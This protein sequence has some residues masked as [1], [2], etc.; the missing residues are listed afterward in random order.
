MFNHPML[1]LVRRYPTVS[2]GLRAGFCLLLLWVFLLTQSLALAAPPGGSWAGGNTAYTSSGKTLTISDL[3]RM[4][5]GAR[6]QQVQP[7]ELNMLLENQG[8]AKNAA[9]PRSFQPALQMFAATHGDQWQ[10]EKTE[11]E[12]KE[13][14]N[15]SGASAGANLH[16]PSGG[17]GN[18]TAV[19]LFVLIA[20]VV[21]G[22]VVLAGGKIVYDMLMNDENT[23]AFF[24]AEMNTSSF[25][26]EDQST[27]PPQVV[28][29]GRLGGLKM[30]FGLE[31]ARMGVGL[32]LEV[33]RLRADLGLDTGPGAESLFLEGYYF[34]A[35]PYIQA[36]TGAQYT[37]SFTPGV[38]VELLAGTSENEEV[39]TISVA[40][41]GFTM[42]NL[43]WQGSYLGL[44]YG[45]I[46][47]S[48]SEKEGLVRK[49]GNF[50]EYVGLS[51]GQRLF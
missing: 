28:D 49:D 36:N 33:G 45:T 21:V 40:R 42:N 35:G 26:F 25:K 39:G 22:F 24:L 29:K 5:P 37:S 18:D 9:Q 19:V 48:I 16:I 11:D 13:A 32:A 4:F 2:M 44:M 31:D 43:F 3:K 15:P 20:L 17:G 23:P 10:E 46:Y 14:R 34:M 50:N 6:L 27:D 47:I 41:I 38:F 51:F 7:W 8:L 30:V 1:Q 12:N